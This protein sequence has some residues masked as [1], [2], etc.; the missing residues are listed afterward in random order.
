MTD[1]EI[2]DA[3][4]NGDIFEKTKG[5]GDTFRDINVVL[6]IRHSLDFTCL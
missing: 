3:I 2:S 1:D 4:D 5:V 6:D